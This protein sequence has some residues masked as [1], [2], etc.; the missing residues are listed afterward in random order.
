[1]SLKVIKE[2]INCL[3]NITKWIDLQNISTSAQYLKFTFNGQKLDQNEVAALISV[4]TKHDT[5]SYFSVSHNKELTDIKVFVDFV[6]RS[7]HLSTL[8]V[9]FCNFDDVGEIFDAFKYFKKLNL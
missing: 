8:N 2:E 6:K 4:L 9:G 1:M 5:T 3:P 7:K